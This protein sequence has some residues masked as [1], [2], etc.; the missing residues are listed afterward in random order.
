MWSAQSCVRQNWCN[1]LGSPLQGS[2]LS[3]SKT[4]DDALGWYIAGPL[5]LHRAS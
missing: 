4:Q 5:A 2:I 3:Y 1:E